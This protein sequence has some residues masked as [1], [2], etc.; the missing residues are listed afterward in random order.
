MRPNT[1]IGIT[2]ES[3]GQPIIRLSR[4]LKVSIGVPK[5]K[6][7][8]VYIHR[9]EWYVRLGAWENKKLVMKTAFKSTS[10]QDTEEFYRNNKDKAALSDRPQKLSFFTFVK[11]SVHEEGGKPVEVFEPDFDAI[12]AHGDTP[13]ELDIVI[14]GDN[15]FHGEYQMWGAAELKCHGD[16]LN[17]LRVISM[18]SAKEAGWQEAKDKGEKYFSI[19]QC[20]TN[21]C[22]YALDGKG[23]KPGAT[24]NFQLANS[25]RMGATAYFH[26]TS[27]RSTYQIFSALE[28]IKTMAER[29]GASIIGLPLKM[30]LAPFRSNHNGIAATQ[31]GVSLELRASDM[32]TL[33]RKL[34]ESN[35]SPKPLSGAP[36][37][38]DAVEELDNTSAPGIVAEFY[39]GEV[40]FE[41]ESVVTDN[42]QAATATAS[43][44]DE[45][46]AKL[47]AKRAES[48]APIE[49]QQQASTEKA[50]LF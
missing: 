29:A 28:T 3:D 2:H 30:V 45:L 37:M 31:Y 10:R 18:G 9:G 13:K 46:A 40:E 21:G 25:M 5:G 27:I 26:T 20:F 35:W 6:A 43:K 1:M 22:P 48:V 23:C 15:C 19:T 11:R 47:A 4:S 16:G 14:M 24:L 32:A 7:V 42:S 8:T 12:E 36:K 44:T 34:A 50:D 41:E 33:R 38:L 17:A 39:E 49:D